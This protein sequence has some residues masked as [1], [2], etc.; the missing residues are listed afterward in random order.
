MPYW[1]VIWIYRLKHPI[2][3]AILDL[4]SFFCAINIVVFDWRSEIEFDSTIKND[5][6]VLFIIIVNCAFFLDMVA[7]FIV[8]GPKKLWF[9]RKV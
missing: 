1:R 6:K 8:I 7:N 9:N 4:L 3:N 5:P 2:Y